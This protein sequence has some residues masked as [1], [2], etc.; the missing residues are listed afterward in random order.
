MD[1]KVCLSVQTYIQEDRL[2][3]S[4][5]S[6]LINTFCLSFYEAPLL[7]VICPV[8]ELHYILSKYVVAICHEATENQKETKKLPTYC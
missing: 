8:D 4:E 1:N 6:F 5:N 3:E 7:N 2:E